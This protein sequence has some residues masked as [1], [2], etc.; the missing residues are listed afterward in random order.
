MLLALGQVMLLFAVTATYDLWTA[1]ADA[2]S[3]LQSNQVVRK[4]QTQDNSP[5]AWLVHLNWMLLLGVWCL[6]CMVSIPTGYAYWTCYIRPT[7]E[8]FLPASVVVPNE[9]TGSFTHGLCDW[10]QRPGLC[11]CFIFCQWFAMGD[12]FYRAGH[13]HAISQNSTPPCQ[14]CPG[15]QFFLGCCGCFLLG[16]AL[17]CCAP[18]ALAA[19]TSGLGFLNQEGSGR[20]GMGSLV[21]FRERFS[22]ESSSGTFCMDCC[23]W[24][25]CLPC[26]AT[27]EYRQIDDLLKQWPLQVN[28]PQVPTMVVGQPVTVQAEAAEPKAKW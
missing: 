11:L 10:F 9:L 4:L 28:A 8:R 25:W 20:S 15:W 22:M 23:L 14:D 24:T 19:L 5:Y 13:T 2:A 3:A 1:Y 27:R 18:C 7:H 17:D 6:I 26:Q 21:P 16:D 12:L